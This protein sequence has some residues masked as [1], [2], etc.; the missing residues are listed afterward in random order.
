MSGA[1]R[2]RKAKPAATVESLNVQCESHGQDSNYLE[3]LRCG[4]FT[5]R[6]N[7]HA[8]TSYATQSRASIELLNGLNGW[9]EVARLLATK[10]NNKGLYTHDRNPVPGA[11]GA[12]P[13]R[14]LPAAFIPDRDALLSIALATLH[15]EG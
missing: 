12:G 2:M 9:T 15:M 3:V 10:I 5:W 6:V 14:A 7:I 4:G 13:Q 8:D 11:F 1:I